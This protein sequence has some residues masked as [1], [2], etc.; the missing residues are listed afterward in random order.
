MVRIKSKV[1]DMLIVGL[2]QYGGKTIEEFLVDKYE[3]SNKEYK[4]FVDAGGYSK[5]EYW[6]HPV[7][8]KGRRIPW[9]DAVKLF[10]DKTG[11][12]G[13]STWEVG[14]FPDGRDSCPVSGVSWYEAAA[15]AEFT[16]KKLPSVYQWSVIAQTGRTKDIIPLSNFNE[17]SVLPV[18]SSKGITSFGVYDIAGN[19]REWCLNEGNGPEHHYILGGGFNDPTYAFNCAY[20]QLS[21]DRSVSNGFR[22][23]IQTGPDSADIEQSGRMKLAFRDYKKEKP[24]DDKTF[25]IY[26]RQFDYDKS[27][28]NAEILPME[29]SDVWKVEKVTINAGYNNERF[30]IWIFLPKN[31]PPPY[32]SVVFFPGSGVIVSDQFSTNDVKRFDFIVKS[33]RAFIYPVLKSTFERRDGLISDLQEETVSYKD[34]VIMWR[35]DIGRTIDYIQER[36]DLIPDKIGYFGFSWG[37]F[38]GGLIPAVENRIRAIV[39]LVGGMQMNRSMPEV[40]QINFLPRVSQ[41][42]L[43]LNGKYDMFFPELTA[44]RPM[45]DFLGSK[46]KEMK[47]YNEGH[48][49]PR[50]DL[51]KETLKWYD[52]Y[53][54]EVKK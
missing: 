22:C 2:E 23:V 34:H 29:N 25:E 6:K 24:V 1:S 50:Q 54:G 14:T 16:H 8:V 49:V 18:G 26:R 17:N 47:V 3:V 53:L 5:I 32:Q 4:K 13:P 28:L 51:V 33:G 12:P 46:D 21:D 37:G 36:E 38:M 27:E 52:K 31:Y 42:V 15:Y 9:E 7:Y 44:Q 41:P 30:N 40:D 10:F 43:M 20:T 11:K 48:L 45:F 35:K 39:L 19:T